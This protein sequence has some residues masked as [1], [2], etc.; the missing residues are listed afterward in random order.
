MKSI[1]RFNKK[2][3][4]YK[5]EINWTEIKLKI[6]FCIACSENHVFLSAILNANFFIELVWTIKESQIWTFK[7]VEFESLKIYRLIGELVKWI[8]NCKS[9]IRINS[10][11]CHLKLYNKMWLIKIQFNCKKFEF[12]FNIFKLIKYFSITTGFI[13]ISLQSAPQWVKFF[14]KSF[15]RS[16][17]LISCGLMSSEGFRQSIGNGQISW[18]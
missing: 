17:W 1:K 12:V 6:N 7:D 16:C 8:N 11:P 3:R 18:L 5:K 9:L 10:W 15:A 2:I 14:M 4:T 13:F